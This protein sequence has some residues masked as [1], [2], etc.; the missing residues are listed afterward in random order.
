MY[1]DSDRVVEFPALKEAQEK[2]DAKRKGLAGI[3]GEAGPEYDM[4]LVKSLQGDTHA[5]VG[6]I[7]A[8]N[9]E[10]DECKAKVDEYLVVARAAAASRNEEKS[11]E[12]GD[13]TSEL[14]FERKGEQR[15]NLGDLFIQSKAFKGYTPGSG[16][17]PN[18]NLDVTLKADF[19][20]SAGWEPESLRTGR[21]ELMPTRPA[22]HV[23]EFFPQTTTTMA[24]VV[25]MEE[26]TFTNAAAERAEN[27]A[28][29]E[30][31]LA[32]TEKSEQVRKVA[33]WL[34]VTDEQFEDEPR[35]RDYVNNRLPFMIRQRLDSQVL[36]GSGA[37]PNL[38]GTENVVGINTQALG[39]DS[40][41]DAIYKGI[42][43]CRDTGFSEPNVVFIAPSKWENVRLL[44]TA[45]GVYIW[46][47]PSMPGPF[48]IWG[49]PVV[50]TTAVTSTK[51]V[52]GDYANFS[53]LALRRGMDVQVT[54]SHGE[55]F[56]SGK[57]AIRA[58]IR[59]A[60]LHYRPLAFCAVTGL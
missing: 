14:Q 38:R 51:A 36:T 12:N 23:T 31:A 49:V 33:V 30:A 47:H 55:F 39:T 60:V 41:P 25:Y 43:K 54:N 52:L 7:G 53:E 56:V 6:A 3:L 20:T 4:A 16:S 59:A 48:T 37:S 19:L 29:P 22:P 1:N 50:E 11:A 24:A 5:K 32:L 18:V 40:I 46:G 10:I 13:G 17:G 27:T 28:Y 57:L 9:K 34:P 8:L 44:K 15:R 26:T 58:D 42:R 45:D 35:A 2:L 21:V